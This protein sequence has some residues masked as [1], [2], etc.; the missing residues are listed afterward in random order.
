MRRLCGLIGLVEA[1]LARKLSRIRCGRADGDSL[2]E[3]YVGVADRFQSPG[4]S[5]ASAMLEV[6]LPRTDSPCRPILVMSLAV[7]MCLPSGC[8]VVPYGEREGYL[9]A[10]HEG[11]PGREIVGV[12]RLASW[13]WA[14]ADRAIASSLQSTADSMTD[15]PPVAE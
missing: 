12:Q 11:I 1:L 5:M 6:K 2:V 3:K 13:P 14:P 4:G 15:A 9:D 10:R 8:A 7:L